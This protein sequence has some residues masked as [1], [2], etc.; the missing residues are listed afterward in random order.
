MPQSSV[1]RI[2]PHFEPLPPVT[3]NDAKQFRAFAGCYP[4]GVAVVTTRDGAGNLHGATMNSVVSLSLDP[5]LYLMCFGAKSSTLGAVL[6]SRVFAINFLAAHQQHISQ[7]FASK[8]PGKFTNLAYEL[9]SNGSP[10]LNGVAGACDGAVFDLH[11]GG[12]HTIVIGKVDNVRTSDRAPL[13]FH[14][15]QYRNFS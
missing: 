5:P 3:L 11:G 10:V 6:E 13:L 4:T 12:D 14:R 2:H 7:I 9:A 1:D 8:E 15:G